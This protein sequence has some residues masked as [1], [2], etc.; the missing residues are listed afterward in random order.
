MFSRRLFVCLTVCL[1]PTSRKNYQGLKYFIVLFCFISYFAIILDGV[2]LSRRAT[3]APDT[4]SAS[5]LL[6]IFLFFFLFVA[7]LCV[8]KDVYIL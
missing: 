7:T 6:L 3:S 5:L 8:N 1:L 4:D 2:H